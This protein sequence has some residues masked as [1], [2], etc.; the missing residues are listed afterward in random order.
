MP[1]RDW[2]F[3]H[4]PAPWIEQAED[5]VE[6]LAQLDNGIAVAA[7]EGNIIVSAFHPE[8]TKDTR[9]HEYFLDIV[10]ASGKSKAG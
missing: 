6:C 10:A 2:S 3:A 4:P 1:L 7:R 9:L 5:G 8:L